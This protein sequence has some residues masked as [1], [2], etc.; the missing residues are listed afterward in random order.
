MIRTRGSRHEL[1]VNNK[2]RTLLYQ[3]AGTSRFAWN[4]GL[5][6]RNARYHSKQGSERFTDA[7]KQH[8]HLNALKQR[9]FAWMYNYSKCV[10][11]EALR[12]L[13][14]AFQNFYQ[15][16][17]DRK[18]GKTTRYVGFPQFKK[19][20]KCK[21]SFRLTGTIRVFPEQKQLQLPRLGKLRLKE[22]PQWP[23]SARILS[24]TIS[25]TA[26]RWYVALQITEEVPDSSSNGQ[27]MVLGLDPGLAKFATFSTGLELPNPKWLRQGQRKL[28][29]LSRAVSRKQK[30][31]NNRRKAV[32]R[33]ARF[34]QRLSACRTN[35]HHQLS[36]YITQNHGVVVTEDLHI[37][38]LK[39]NKQQS[40]SWADVAHGEFRRQLLYK[41]EWH[42]AHYIAIPR[43]YPSSKLCS[44]CWYYHTDLALKDRMFECPMCGLTLDRD[45]NAALNME[46]YYHCRLFLH[47][48]YSVAGSLS[49]TLNACGEVVRPDGFRRTSMKQ[50]ISGNHDKRAIDVYRC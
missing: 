22:R 38:S 14:Q 33:L 3:C 34:H 2:E 23:S 43:F 31:S 18:A 16:H 12:D 40:K 24:A 4:W 6:D 50:E 25:R 9:D 28:R 26:D 7:M 30:G 8:K 42:G 35:H 46:Q 37:A 47:P 49:E 20:G 19:K 10:P 15:N 1:K 17:K 36:A 27:Q 39:K 45:L 5:A 32:R 41:S 44:T 21:D 11:Q 29:R 48:G 13:E